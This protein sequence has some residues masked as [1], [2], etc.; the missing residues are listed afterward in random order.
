MVASKKKKYIHTKIYNKQK[1]KQK[2][3]EIRNKQHALHAITIG[4][5]IAMETF[6]SLSLAEVR[7]I[8][9][10]EIDLQY[11]QNRF[12]CHR[13]WTLTLGPFYCSMLFTVCYSLYQSSF[14]AAIPINHNYL[15]FVLVLWNCS[16]PL[17][18]ITLRLRV[19]GSWQCCTVFAADVYSWSEDKFGQSN[20]WKHQRGEELPCTVYPIQLAYHTIPPRLLVAPCCDR[21]SG[22]VKI[23]LSHG[24]KQG[25][26]GFI[27]GIFMS[28]PSPSPASDCVI[29]QGRAIFRAM[30]RNR[31]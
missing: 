1:R 10:H 22:R 29:M 11:L 13:H 21:M 7:Q 20:H 15:A 6:K 30:W 24:A 2:W 25:G 14:F 27:G 18:W 4:L 3:R 28:P 5:F 16:F 19:V 17:T 9:N 12:C 8:I 23:N 31:R 26:V